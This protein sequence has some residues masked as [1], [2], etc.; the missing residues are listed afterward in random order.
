MPWKR[1]W[2]AAEKSCHAIH[3]KRLEGI[4]DGIRSA[5]AQVFEDTD[6]PSAGEIIPPEGWDL[7]E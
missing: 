2:E 7:Y 5:G 1:V 6:L 3:S 4:I